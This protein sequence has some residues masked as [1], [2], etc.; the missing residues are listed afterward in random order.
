MNWVDSFYAK[1]H[2]W[3]GVYGEPIGPEHHERAALIEELGGEP[4]LRVLEL[5]CGGGQVARAIA[6]RG[7]TVVAVDLNEDAIEHARRL[8]AGHATA[9]RPG[10]MA[11]L[12]SDFY[13]VELEGS[14]D[15]VCYFDGFGIGSDEDQR[16]LLR[17]IA[18]WLVPGGRALIEIY[19][20]WYWAGVAGRTMAWADTSRRYDYDTAAKRML[21]TWWPTNDP[22]AAVTQS[23]ACYAPDALRTLL[24]PT[25]LT[26]VNVRPGGAYDHDAGV[27]RESAPLGEAMQY[28]AVLE[29]P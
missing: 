7:H 21:D 12:H 29:R 28:I 5:G 24:E 16:R 2:E 23:L 26:L 27:Y 18:G 3:T 13:T 6:N 1:Q 20:P 14:F 25:G 9:K 22:S 8:A 4:P 15:I 17:R 19:T 10:R 11:V